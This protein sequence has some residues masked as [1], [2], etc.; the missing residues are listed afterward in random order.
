MVQALRAVQLPV[1]INADGT[2]HVAAEFGQERDQ[3]ELDEVPVET[4]QL[5]VHG[6]AYGQGQ[7]R[8][9]SFLR[10]AREP[11]SSWA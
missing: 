4:V 9:S 7:K 8:G 10:W 1:D 6:A 5:G 2:Q 11:S 3:F